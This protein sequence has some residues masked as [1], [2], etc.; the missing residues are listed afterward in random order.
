MSLQV[1]KVLSWWAFEFLS[2]CV[3]VFLSLWAVEFSW[4]DK[5]ANGFVQYFDHEMELY[6]GFASQ[7]QQA[8][9][10]LQKHQKR[11]Q[12]QWEKRQNDLNLQAFPSAVGSSFPS[13]AP[14]KSHT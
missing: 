14:T 12:P 1:D 9:F 5:P 11:R 2:W 8:T 13:D 7:R 6:L 4:V 3:D 10:N